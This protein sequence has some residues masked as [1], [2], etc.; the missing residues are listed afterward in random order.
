MILQ[1]FIFLSDEKLEKHKISNIV[2]FCNSMKLLYDNVVNTHFWR[3]NDIWI[4][5]KIISILSFL[6]F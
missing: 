4:I 3:N 5:N 2:L 6:S 1:Y